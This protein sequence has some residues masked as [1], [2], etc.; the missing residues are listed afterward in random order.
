MLESVY[1]EHEWNPKLFLSTKKVQKILYNLITKL[2]PNENI[3]EDYRHPEL[4]FAS[5]S[6]MELDIYLPGK[7]LAFE[8]NGYTFTL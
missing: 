1:P 7:N 4:R 8:Y 3:L 5:N 6:R 2:F